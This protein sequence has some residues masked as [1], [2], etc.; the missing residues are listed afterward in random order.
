M[1]THMASHASTC[2]AT[3]DQHN[4]LILD[5]H[6]PHNRTDTSTWTRPWWPGRDGH[7]INPACPLLNAETGTPAEG[8]GWLNLTNTH[9]LCSWCFVWD[10]ECQ[11]CGATLDDDNPGI[12]D[13][14]AARRWIDSHVC[15]PTYTLTPR[16]RPAAAP[17]PDIKGQLAL[18][19]PE[20]TR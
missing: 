7:H 1:T 2:R 18:T 14:A 9:H 20:A 4:P 6:N 12:H 10:A 3:L 19:G 16:P 17:A 15:L 8:S 5:H 11:N 13:Q